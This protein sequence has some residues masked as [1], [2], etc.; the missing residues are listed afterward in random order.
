MP[1]WEGRSLA[2]AGLRPKNTRRSR[3]CR[4]AGC[5]IQPRCSGGNATSTRGAQAARGQRCGTQGGGGA[6]WA[7]EVALRSTRG[8]G[9]GYGLRCGPPPEVP[10]VPSSMAPPGT[11]VKSAASFLTHTPSYGAGCSTRGYVFAPR[12]SRDIVVCG[13]TIRYS[14]GARGETSGRRNGR[15]R[16]R[17]GSRPDARRRRPWGLSAVHGSARRATRD[18]AQC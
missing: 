8:G 13:N 1:G 17:P 18:P 5:R 9:H 4:T 10:I 3:V 2:P 14:A 15:P 6:P 11:Q 16:W 7:V 12:G